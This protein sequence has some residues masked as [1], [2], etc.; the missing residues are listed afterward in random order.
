MANTSETQSI[1]SNGSLITSS[2]PAPS[3]SG[4]SSS[5]SHAGMTSFF[6]HAD[7]QPLSS[8]TATTTSTTPA[9]SNNS[10]SS[11]NV[12]PRKRTRATPEQLAVLEKTFSI[13]PSPNTRVREQ[14]SR[15]LGMSE[16]S[17]QI[18]FQNRRAKAKN[19]FKRSTMLHEETIRMQYYAASA[20]AAACQA[21]NF[22]QQQ[23]SPDGTVASNPDLYYYYYCY[24]YNQQQQQRQRQYGNLYPSSSSTVVP[25]PPLPMHSVPPPPPPPPPSELAI[26]PSVRS[27]TMTPP[28]SS[29]SS[30]TS[31]PLRHRNLHEERMR[32]HSLGPYPY[33]PYHR[34]TRLHERTASIDS[35]ASA[36]GSM[37]HYRNRGYASASPAPQMMN[38][39]QQ[40]QQAP[41]RIDTSMPMALD[42]SGLTERSPADNSTMFGFTP[43]SSEMQTVPYHPLTQSVIPVSTAVPLED[44][45]F[46]TPMSMTAEEENPPHRF[47]A[48]ALQIGTWKRMNLQRQ[49]LICQYHP[50]QRLMSWCIR[51][52]QQRFKMQFSIDIVQSMQLEP[53]SERL[54]WARL[55]L[56]LLQPELISFFMEDAAR[57]TWTQCRDFTQDQQATTGFRHFLDG[58]ALAL[59]AEL[60][61]LAQV[62]SQVLSLMQPSEMQAIDPHL[63]N[64]YDSTQVDLTNTRQARQFPLKDDDNLVMSDGNSNHNNNEQ[65]QELLLFQGLES[66]G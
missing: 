29:S 55:E 48:E 23:M 3:P 32:A 24:Y 19:M 5:T 8:T 26:N 62:D 40:Q 37:Y 54:G 43:M 44:M 59:R 9:V 1:H 49:D 47:S 31:G 38:W 7:Q 52:G 27:W 63:L 28:P 64:L 33:H 16:R 45:R 42:T 13:N 36:G 22:H 58:P 14:L 60:T 41:M 51:D 17:I 66:Q 56:R 57:Q 30:P 65:S 2:S 11:E 20:A 10:Q 39:Q 46:G 21:A 18:W 61:R 12:P 15:E 25:P 53:L 6:P 34:A 35:I 50:Q 4:A